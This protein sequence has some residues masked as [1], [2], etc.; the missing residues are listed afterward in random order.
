MDESNKLKF[1]T[2]PDGK[3]YLVVDLPDGP[4]QIN[5]PQEYILKLVEKYRAKPSP[6]PQGLSQNH[7]DNE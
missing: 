3:K 2:K 6:E 4:P 5:D 7:Q 1:I